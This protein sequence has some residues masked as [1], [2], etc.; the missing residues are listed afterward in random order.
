MVKL[1]VL[2]GRAPLCACRRCEL[3]GLKKACDAIEGTCV[4]LVLLV[5]VVALGGLL[6]FVIEP[7]GPPN[8]PAVLHELKVDGDPT[9]RL[10]CGALVDG[11][12]CA[13]IADSGRFGSVDAAV[14]GLPPVVVGLTPLRNSSPSSEAMSVIR[15][16]MTEGACCELAPGNGFGKELVTGERRPLAAGGD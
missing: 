4:R 16:E 1:P 2:N 6:E 5:A 15:E 13:D 10:D 12:V 14:P 9:P 3:M 11:R 8:A 7:P